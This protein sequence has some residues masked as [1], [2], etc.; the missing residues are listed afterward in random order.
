MQLEINDYDKQIKDAAK[1]HEKLFNQVII[2]FEFNTELFVDSKC[3]QK[4]Q[5]RYETRKFYCGSKFTP[6]FDSFFNGNCSLIFFPF[7]RLKN[8]VL[9][10]AI[11]L[12]TPSIS[13][14][15]T[16]QIE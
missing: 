1:E 3:A 15:P 11:N 14:N 2:I 8:N 10:T 4:N 5:F 13:W 7:F 16:I 9:Q 12:T 6:F